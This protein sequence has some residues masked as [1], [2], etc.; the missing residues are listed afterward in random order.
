[1]QYWAECDTLLQGGVQDTYYALEARDGVWQ[2]YVAWGG[3]WQAW[4]AWG[5]VW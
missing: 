1:M 2:A 5:C 3:V 4:A